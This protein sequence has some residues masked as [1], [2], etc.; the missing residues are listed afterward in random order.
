LAEEDKRQPVDGPGQA[1]Q[2]SYRLE[3]RRLVKINQDALFFLT[4]LEKPV[5][6]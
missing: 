2:V 1:F 6:V 4:L 3:S 5:R